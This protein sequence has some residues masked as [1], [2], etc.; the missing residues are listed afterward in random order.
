M[1]INKKLTM[2]GLSS[3]E[4]VLASYDRSP[5]VGIELELNCLELE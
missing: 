5:Q 2:T 4:N 1:T 3:Q